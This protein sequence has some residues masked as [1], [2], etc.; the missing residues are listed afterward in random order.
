[1]I[2]EAATTVVEHCK[3]V[4]I[5]LQKDM[6]D[7]SP[8]VI[9]KTQIWLNGV[10]NEGYETFV[11][12]QQKP[13]TARGDS[14]FQFC[15]TNRRP[16]DLAVCLLLLRISKLAPDAMNLNSDGN[17]DADWQEARKTYYSL[18]GEEAINFTLE[19]AS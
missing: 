5:A 1:M 14:Y 3:K 7:C 18:F 19:K 17:W 2:M 9:N 15:K 12:N 11:L 16:Y 4:G 8:V 10:D 13:S 6:S